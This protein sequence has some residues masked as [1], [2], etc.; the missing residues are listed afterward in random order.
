MLLGVQPERGDELGRQGHRHRVYVPFGTHW[1]Q[2]SVRRLQEN[3][4]MADY[5]AADTLRRLRRTAP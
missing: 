5:A 3:P 4:R 1:Y 2:Y